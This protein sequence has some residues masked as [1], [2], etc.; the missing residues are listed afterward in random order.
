MVYSPSGDDCSCNWGLSGEAMQSD[1]TEPGT[2]GP[3]AA[4][5]GVRTELTSRTIRWGLGC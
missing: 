1:R 5:D 3:G 4:W 2:V